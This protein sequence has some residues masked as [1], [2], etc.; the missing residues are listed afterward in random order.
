MANSVFKSELK[1]IE[2]EI[3]KTRKIDILNRELS[4]YG[5]GF[6]HPY[7]FGH[8]VTRLERILSRKG[9]MEL[10]LK[11]F[12]SSR[13]L[14]LSLTISLVQ[15]FFAHRPYLSSFLPT[16]EESIV[17]SLQY[18]YRAAVSVL[19]P[20]IEGAVRQL[21]V[22]EIGEEKFTKASMPWLSE[23]LQL[24]S[25][26]YRNSWLKYF[27]NN[28]AGVNGCKAPLEKNEL[29]YLLDK[30]VEYFEIW[31]V[32]LKR[33][34]QQTMYKNANGRNVEDTFNRNV[35]FHGLLMDVEYSLVNY[36]RLFNC[37]SYLSWIIGCVRE[38]CSVLS[39]SETDSVIITERNYL[40]IMIYSEKVRLLKES[41]YGRS[42][43]S[44]TLFLSTEYIIEVLGNGSKRKG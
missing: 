1:I 8:D 29:N 23:N 20:V 22:G 2:K 31:L 41:I 19:L 28:Y 14:D 42:I 39:L 25:Q 33:F 12:F 6:F 43:P 32:Q 4:D 35:I 44:H 21:L 3:V 38:D 13:F 10:E 5:W 24:L 9:D 30:H 11:N 40:D 15:G 27:E 36:I 37:L 34:L 16:I 17:L 18:D 26:Q 7:N